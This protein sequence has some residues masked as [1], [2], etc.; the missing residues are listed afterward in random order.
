MV[1][2]L[3]A[4]SRPADHIH[5]V[6]VQLM[7]ESG[8]DLAHTKPRLLTAELA[9]GAAWIITMGCGEE[10]PVV[11]GA[12]RE[13]WPLRDPKGLP[14]REVAAIR[15]EIRARVAALLARM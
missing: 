3:A 2:A 1:R 5:P 11:P 7:N 10:C 6:V 8:I 9:E 12:L 15:D 4:G 13:D 14:P